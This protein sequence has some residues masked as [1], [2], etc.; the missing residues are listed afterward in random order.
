MG[1]SEKRKFYI[2][3]IVKL[4]DRASGAQLRVIYRFACRIVK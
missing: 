1:N 3:Y 4:L 2:E